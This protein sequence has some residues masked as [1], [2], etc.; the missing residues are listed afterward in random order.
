MF[1][2]NLLKN[3]CSTQ[4]L[5]KVAAAILLGVNLCNTVVIFVERFYKI[6]LKIFQT[7]GVLIFF[8]EY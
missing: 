7:T 8:N 5:N 1:A 4:K 2:K 3:V 6:N